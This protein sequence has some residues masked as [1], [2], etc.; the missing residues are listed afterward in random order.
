VRLSEL[1]PQV[2]TLLAKAERAPEDCWTP[3][4]EEF[5]MLVSLAHLFQLKLPAD[6]LQAPRRALTLLRVARQAMRD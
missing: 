4:K 2:E 5:A 3:S 6:E 1:R